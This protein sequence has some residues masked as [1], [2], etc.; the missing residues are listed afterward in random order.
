M[1]SAIISG[2]LP[3]MSRLLISTVFTPD[4]QIH[5]PRSDQLFESTIPHIENDRL[6]EDR[7]DDEGRLGVPRRYL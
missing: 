1:N 2:E 3:K 4:Q 7:S 6:D 5:Q